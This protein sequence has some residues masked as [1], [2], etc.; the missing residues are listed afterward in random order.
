M[1]TP[2]SR[3]NVALGAAWAAPAV[4]VATAAPAFAASPCDLSAIDGGTVDG[5]MMRYDW[6]ITEVRYSGSDGYLGTVAWWTQVYDRQADASIQAQIAAACPG[7]SQEVFWVD[8]LDDPLRYTVEIYRLEGGNESRFRTHSLNAA[9]MNNID[10]KASKIVDPRGNGDEGVQDSRPLGPGKAIYA[11][12]MNFV[13]L[14][15]VYELNDDHRSYVTI[16]SGD[17]GVIGGRIYNELRIDGQVQS[18]ENEDTDVT[19]F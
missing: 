13:S 5:R 10:G 14:R 7:G 4:A 15:S 3:R 12:D 18:F 8:N 1:H 19:R 17:G 11:W 2:I 6:S 9:D 16:S